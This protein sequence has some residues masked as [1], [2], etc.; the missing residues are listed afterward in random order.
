MGKRDAVDENLECD[1]EEFLVSLTLLIAEGRTPEC[2][3]K[4]RTEGFHCP[5]AQS[6]QVVSAKHEC[7]DKLPQCLQARKTRSDV[8]LL[9]RN[10]IPIMVEVMLLP[11]C[12]YSDDGPTSESSDINDPAFKQDALLLERWILEPVPRQSGDR[13]IDEKTLLLAVR[14]Y[15]FFSQLSAWLSASHG[16]V[17]RNIIYRVSA[18][19]EEP[20]WKFTQTPTE[21]VFPV[22]NI[23]SNVALKVTVQSLP[24]QPSYPVLNCSIHTSISLFGKQI[25]DVRHACNSVRAELYKSHSP[26]WLAAKQT[27]GHLC[28]NPVYTRKYPPPED[29]P[30]KTLCLYPKLSKESE[31]KHSHDKCFTLAVNDTYRTHSQE[32]GVKTLKSL[33]LTDSHASVCQCY[34]VSAGETSPLIGSLLRDRQEV[35]ARIAQN[36]NYCDP[37]VPH[38]AGHPFNAYEAEV[39]DSK[40]FVGLHEEDC[41]VKKC[42]ESL[43]GPAVRRESFLEKDPEGKAKFSGTPCSFQ[44]KDD[45]DREL[46]SQIRRKLFLSDSKDISNLEAIHDFSE[47]TEVCQH[48]QKCSTVVSSTCSAPSSKSTVGSTKGADLL[49]SCCEQK[50][51]TQCT[52]RTK[53]CSKESTEK[54]AYVNSRC[55]SKM[56]SCE[57]SITDCVFSSHLGKIKKTESAKAG[58]EMQRSGSLQFLTKCLDHKDSKVKI[59]EASISKPFN[60]QLFNTE[61]HS[62]KEN[63]CMQWK[64][65]LGRLVHTEKKDPLNY[66]V[67]HGLLKN[68]REGW[69]ATPEQLTDFNTLKTVQQVPLKPSNVWKRQNRHSLDELVTKAFHPRTGLPLLSSPV[70]QRK[71]QSRYFD[72]DTSLLRLKSL[73]EKRHC[74]KTEAESESEDSG[75][76]Q[77]SASAPPTTSLSLLGNFEECVLNYRL[78]PLGTVEGFTADVGASGIFCPNHINLPVE[79]L[80]YSVSDDNA[81]SPYM[82]V[83]NLE[84]LGKRGYRVPPSGTIQVVP[85]Y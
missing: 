48:N 22:P 61:K 50:D 77:L 54:Q 51:Q 57:S 62:N 18:A 72:L 44:R 19:D 8:I 69:E 7:S 14:S 68:C 23:S 59:S 25:Q 60:Y 65:K 74:L 82:G 70:P 41:S 2:S 27:L 56:I 38:V 31:V 63:D 34:R 43:L 36:L 1:A 39:I 20:L 33:S 45:H 85:E 47:H 28:E 11:D 42:K 16:T 52:E 26:P 40:G 49:K 32:Q 73:P 81:P 12:C 67:K 46:H 80:F 10:N 13:F 6:S 83:I 76:Q 53:Q 58:T 24:R 30:L 75:R 29:A 55:K 35:I 9:W 3:L 15:V 5:P 64:D 78:D 79:V 4:G 84:S 37:G 66:E 17:P 21:H 71:T